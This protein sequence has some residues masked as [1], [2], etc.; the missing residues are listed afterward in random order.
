[1]TSDAETRRLIEAREHGVA[2][3]KWGPY[4]SERQW[5]T[6]REDYS[7]N[8]SATNTERL[9]GA[10]NASPFAKDGINDYVVGGR[11]D[12]VNPARTGTKAAAHYRLDVPAGGTRVVRLRLSDVA[13]AAATFGASFDGVMTTRLRE[14]DAFYDAVTPPALGADERLVMRQ[15]LA[16]M[17][18]SK[19]GGLPAPPG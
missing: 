9:F 14:A 12:A 17:L 2:W 5:G 10:P 11:P 1:V 18:W 7:D 15:A 13:P 19:T 8:G 6:V 4:L 16:G 3:R